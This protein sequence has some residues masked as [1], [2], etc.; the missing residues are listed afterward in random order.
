MGSKSVFFFPIGQYFASIFKKMHSFLSRANEV[1]AYAL[2]VLA[3]LTFLCFLSAL[4][5]DYQLEAKAAL[6]DVQLK[7]DLYG[8]LVINV[9]CLILINERKIYVKLLDEAY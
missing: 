8:F 3:H 4:F 9:N 1:V 6:P 7:L 2:S 5:N